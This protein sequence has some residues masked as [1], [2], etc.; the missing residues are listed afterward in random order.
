MQ[1][2]KNPKTLHEHFLETITGIDA[3]GSIVIDDI[4]VGSIPVNTKDKT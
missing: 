1:N 2:I 3:W 4:H